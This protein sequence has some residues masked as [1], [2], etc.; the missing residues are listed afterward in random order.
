MKNYLLASLFLIATL[1]GIVA[2]NIKYKYFR[3]TLL[4]TFAPFSDPIIQE[5]L[6]KLVKISLSDKIDLITI[7]SQSYIFSNFPEPPKNRVFNSK[8]AV[9]E[10]NQYQESVLTSTQDNVYDMARQFVGVWFD[11][12]RDGY[13]SE[14]YLSKMG[15]YTAV[16]QDINLDQYTEI[17]RLNNIGYDLI[18]KSYI[19]IYR[20][21]S[22]VSWKEIYDKQDEQL[23]KLAQKTNTT[24]KPVLRQKVGYFLNYDV[25]VYKLDWNDATIDDFYKNYYVDTTF[26]SGLSTQ[27]KNLQLAEKRSKI[28]NFNNF[29]PAIKLVATFNLNSE[30]ANDIYIDYNLSQMSY[31]IQATK[32][33]KTT[34]KSTTPPVIDYEKKGD[35]AMQSKNYGAAMELYRMALNANPK[36][37]GLKSKISQA[38]IAMRGTLQE[39]EGQKYADNNLVVALKRAFVELI[40][41]K[42]YTSMSNHDD[43]KDDFKVITSISGKTL[44]KIK[45]P[46][47]TKEDLQVSQRYVAYELVE[48]NGALEKNY[49]GYCRA[50]KNMA[51]NKGKI[52]G[53]MMPSTLGER[54]EPYNTSSSLFVQ[55]AGKK[56]NPGVLLEYE[57][58]KGQRYTLDFSLASYP[59]ISTD[60]LGNE[61]INKNPYQMITVGYG[62]DT[63]KIWEFFDGSKRMGPQNLYL[64]LQGHY[65]MINKETDDSFLEG[66]SFGAGLLIEREIYTGISGLHVIPSLYGGYPIYVKPG[67]GIGY[68]LNRNLTLAV[69]KQFIFPS[70]SFNFKYR[71]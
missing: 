49:I 38:D 61:I 31:V 18:S 71:L 8:K 60:D 28:A 34:Q 44:T 30:S 35:E 40:Q 10:Q 54:F 62:I 59:T 36:N 19:V 46:I 13:M 6:Q 7:P 32:P 9:Y 57:P 12:N 43:I 22:I 2:Q 21:K 64:T 41:D 27:E 11:R 17:S 66:M 26:K 37:T 65:F 50:T 53:T 3:P 29:R 25:F 58:D 1:N 45:A 52:S 55:Q 16:Q 20:V 68:N 70:L 69:N 33:P 48:K 51:Q 39:I 42:T 4:Q 67:L 5:D 56:L 15:A 47:G 23:L 24:F 63:R 14:N